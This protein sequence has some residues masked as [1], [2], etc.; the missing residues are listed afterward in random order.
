MRRIIITVIL[1][2]GFTLVYSQEEMTQVWLSKLEHKIVYT[3]TGM[4]DRGYSFAASDKEMTVFKNADGKTLWTK[5][6]KE[7]APKLNKIDELI[8]FWEGNTVFLFDRKMGKDQMACIDLEKGTYLWSTDKYQD[9]TDDV[10]RY[11]PE[12]EGFAISLKKS[13]VFIKMRTG[14]EVW[15]TDKFKGVVGKYVYD[16]NERA[17]VMVNFVPG[18]V[19]SLF[20]GFKNQIAKINVQNGEI[21]WE[22]TYVGRAERKV[23]T[24]EFVF[25][26][27]VVGNQVILRI[28][29]YQVYDYKTGASLWSAAFDF[30]PEGLVPKPAG[31]IKFGA[32]GTV[33]E[34]VTVGDDLYILDMSNKKNQ[35]V[36]K[37][38]KNTGKLLWS[39]KEIKDARVIPGMYIVG[40][41]VLLQI[42]GRVETQFYRQIKSGDYIYYIWGVAHPEVKPFGIQAFNT[43]DGSLAWE[44][45]RFKKGITNAVMVGD[46]FVVSSG[47]ALY[48]LDMNTGAEKYEVP[49]SKGGVGEAQLI[50]QFKENTIVVVGE[51]G[52]SNFNAKT[53]DLICKGDYKSSS[54]EDRVDDLLIMKTDKAD[55][56]A[57]DLNTCTYKEYKARTGARTD[58]SL[59]GKYVYIYEKNTVTKVATGKK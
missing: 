58:M 49:V 52:I 1:L 32:Y 9:V 2:A 35:F 4:E 55:M 37:Y 44:S 57:Y 7:L 43:S 21:I 23:L 12:E 24:R 46:Q 42:G 56:A 17:M 34:P 50:L 27:D 19:A 47:K 31:T 26:L 59:D 18:A 22:N 3:G 28:N 5:P 36:K 6:F 38:D 29:G 30:V 33:A 51:K 14:E 20:T 16:V 39:S 11:I 48:S 45:E 54:L 10:I 40:D 15:Q 41:K 25:D 8:P 13:L 53:G